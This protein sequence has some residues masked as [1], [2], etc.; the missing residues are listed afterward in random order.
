MKRITYILKWVK[1]VYLLSVGFKVLS[2]VL[3]FANSIF[4]ARLLGV[5][6]LG[7]YA[8]F[9]S[10]AGLIAAI[11]NIALP[12]IL[13]R[14]TAR[15][16]S[17]G[18]MKMLK[19]I[20]TWAATTFLTI[21]A[22]W[23]VV[24]V[25][26]NWAFTDAQQNNSLYVTLIAVAIF[27]L[28]GVLFMFSAILRGSGLRL[29]GQFPTL[30]LQPALFS[31][32]LASL[33][34]LGEQAS[35]V[36]FALFAN[37]SSMFSALIISILALLYFRPLRR[38]P[39]KQEQSSERPALWNSLFHHGTASVFQYISAN[40]AIILLAALGATA[41]AG[42]FRVSVALS[43]IVLLPLRAIYATIN[44]RISQFFYSSET[45][46]MLDMLKQT[47][48]IVVALSGS[49]AV[50]LLVFGP[51]VIETAYGSDFEPAYYVVCILIAGNFLSSAFGPVGSILSMTGNEKETAKTVVLAAILA[52]VLNVILLPSL[53]AI[54]AAIATV[55]ATLFWN[56][57]MWYIVRYRLGLKCALIDY[58]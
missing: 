15:F 26:F 22:L 55:S 53:G 45:S 49:L 6:D 56:A 50:L 43:A 3:L 7:V 8:N 4:L 13:V 16:W 9:I 37:L 23:A 14:E 41:D 18:D 57:R 19:Q 52:C 58:V 44:P 2:T 47:L 39:Q 38:R 24:V 51:F 34:F 48:F 25:F 33:F 40:V 32:A 27:G 5:D 17:A 11:G 10:I 54:G 29:V 31:I 28:S 30:I 35:C 1:N 46:K 12:Q 21:F 42:I 36:T 20:W